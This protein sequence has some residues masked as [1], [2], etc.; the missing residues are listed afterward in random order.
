MANGFINGLSCALHFHAD[1]VDTLLFVVQVFGL[2]L[3]SYLR[4]LLSTFDWSVV[5]H[6]HGGIEAKG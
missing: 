1:S 6:L 3:V 2:E 4:L 5:T